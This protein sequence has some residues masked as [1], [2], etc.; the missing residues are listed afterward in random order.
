MSPGNRAMSPTMV[1][2]TSLP[3]PVLSKTGLTAVQI[4]CPLG[5]FE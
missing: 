3:I 4:V 5:S 1:G 2:V